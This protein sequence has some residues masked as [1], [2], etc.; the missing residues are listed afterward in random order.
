LVE[1]PFGITLREMIYTIGGG[2]L[3]DKQFKA[4]QTGGPSGGSIPVSKIDI[5]V[6]YDSLSAV[7]TIMGSG[8]M[9]VMDE[10]NC[11]VD[12]SH[13]F[14]DFTQ[15][16][17]CGECVPCRLGTKQMLDILEKITQG[18]GEPKDLDMLEELCAAI[19]KGS[20]CGLGQTAPNPVESTLRYFREEYEAHINDKTCP[21]AA[22]K[23]LMHFTIQEDKCIGCHMCAKNC[24]VN[25]I[26]G[27]M[28]KPHVIDQEKCI[29]CG[30]CFEVCPKKVQAVK[31]IPGQYKAG[32][33]N[34]A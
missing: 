23:A 6:D 17:S 24:A 3:S 8:G 20:L 4:V 16:E 25:A 9:V 18:K 27:E 11:M 5:P 12:V 31:K 29:K 22:C 19:K 10:D 15:K 14:L 32:G 1:V 21:A 30:M 13:Y 33:K 26:V 2:I 7:G 34:H 28:K